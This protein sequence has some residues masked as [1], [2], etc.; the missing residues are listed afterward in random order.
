MP[1]KYRVIYWIL[2]LVADSFPFIGARRLGDTRVCGQRQGLPALPGAP[3]GPAR[4]SQGIAPLE[5]TAE[6]C[7]KLR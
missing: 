2:A 3:A 1:V 4:G 7:G 6:N 5:T